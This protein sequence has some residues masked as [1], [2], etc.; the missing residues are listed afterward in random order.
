MQE[1][2]RPAFNALQRDLQRHQYALRPNRWLVAGE[3]PLARIGRV[4]PLVIPEY[5]PVVFP[6]FGAILKI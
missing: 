3:V 4:D 2:D 1:Q 5:F 6:V